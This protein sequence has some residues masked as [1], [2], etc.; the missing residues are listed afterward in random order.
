[1]IMYYYVMINVHCSNVGCNLG[2]INV[3]QGVILVCLVDK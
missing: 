1:M 3:S 2:G